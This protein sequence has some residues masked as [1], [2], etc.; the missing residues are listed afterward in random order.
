MKYKNIIQKNNIDNIKTQQIFSI[1]TIFSDR[2]SNIFLK[3]DDSAKKFN[4]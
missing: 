1:I 2:F 3:V 4:K